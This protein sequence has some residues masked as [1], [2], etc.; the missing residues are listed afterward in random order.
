MF[1]HTHVE[2]VSVSCVHMGM[3]GNRKQISSRSHI[4]KTQSMYPI[5]PSHAEHDN[6]MIPCARIALHDL[7]HG[8]GNEHSKQLEGVD[9]RVGHPI[10]WSMVVY[11]YPVRVV[12]MC[13]WCT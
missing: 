11:S 13:P 8:A 12:S 9:G 4:P 5:E 1:L 7:I 3:E 2:L 6:P 10:A